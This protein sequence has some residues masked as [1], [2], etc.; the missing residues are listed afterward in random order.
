[1]KN[2]IIVIGTQPPCPRCSLLT[3]ILE[4]KVAAMNLP[5][6]VRHISFTSEEAQKIAAAQGLVPGTA[7]DVAKKL[8]VEIRIDDL[9]DVS[10]NK[11]AYPPVEDRELQHLQ[12]LFNEVYLLD[13]R[14]RNFENQA[15]S[16]GILMTPVLV[17]NGSILYTGS[18]P[19]LAKIRRWL[20]ELKW[21][22]LL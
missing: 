19:D 9:G 13:N 12:Q 17:I 16:T 18:V 2:E 3:Q 5:A 20:L 21:T 14:L 10:A 7:K 8:G 6:A 1:M 4:M 22:E 11:A 15:E